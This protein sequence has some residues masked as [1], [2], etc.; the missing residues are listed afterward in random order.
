MGYIVR[1]ALRYCGAGA[2]YHAQKS[3]TL[4]FEPTTDNINCEIVRYDSC[5][6]EKF[7]KNGGTDKNQD[8]SLDNQD[9]PL[10]A[11]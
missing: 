2:A 11:Y 1:V 6:I 3:E 9:N 10:S 7:L 4:A 8:N 5:L